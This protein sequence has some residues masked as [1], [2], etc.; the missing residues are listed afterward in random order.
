MPFLA[1]SI[2]WVIVAL[3]SVVLTTIAFFFIRNPK[4]FGTTRLLL[5]VLAIDTCRNIFENTYFGIYFGSLY[6]FLPHEIVDKLGQPFL[7]ILPKI[8]NVIAGCVV[9]GLLLLRWLPLA[10]RERGRVDQRASDLETLAAHDWLTGLYNRR[11]FE[12]LAQAELARS[13][14]YFRPLS[15][16]MIDLD[17][18]K[19]IN[20]LYGHPIGDRVLQ[21]VATVCLAT[22]RD[23]DV[24][25][26]IG[27]EEFAVMLPETI[28]T[29]AAQFAERLRKQITE[30]AP[31]VDGEQ[32]TVTA[33]IGIV[34]GDLSTSGV[35]SLMRHADQ[36]LYDAKRAGRNRVMVWRPPAQVAVKEAAE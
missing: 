23:S 31:V 18:F 29:A 5:A 33:S 20:D 7:L 9:L 6:G 19:T 32:L 14:R 26:R 1:A 35:A 16:L 15:M 36:A 27:G 8:L 2:Y 11:H 13:Q 12:A 17:H 21:A 4:A 25:A 22:K 24:V 34:T 28:G 30:C 3:W 10:I